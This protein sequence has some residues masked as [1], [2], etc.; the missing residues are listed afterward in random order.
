MKSN[1][2]R[3][4]LA[5]V[6]SFALWLYV[7]SVVSPES[8]DTFYDIPVSY[9]NDILEER[10]LMIVSETPTVTLKLK[11]NRSDLNE[12]NA[13]NITILVDLSE[14][15]T[16]GTQM[17][18]Y[19]VTYPANLPGNA[20]KTLSQTP[21][22][23]QLKVESKIKKNVPVYVEYI[24]SVP[25][26]FVAEKETPVMDTTIVEVS[27]PK[28]SV[29]LIH[30]ATIQ[31]DL[32]DKTESIVGA[33]NYVLCNEEGEPVDAQMVVTNVEEINMSVKI[34]AIKE[35]PLVLNLVDGGGATSDSCQ[36]ELSR[37]TIV[38]S[39]NDARLRE[40]EYIEL[41]TV[42]LAELMDETN[43]I[44]FQIVLPDGITNSSGVSEVTA[45]ITFPDLMRKKFT[46]SKEQFQ[47]IGV[48]EGANVVWITEVV[49]VELRGLRETIQKLSE[50][51]I[52]VTVDFT[53]EDLGSISKTPKIS[54]PRA[55]A[56]VGEVSVSSVTAT[57]QMG[58]PDATTSTS[59]EQ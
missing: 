3:L 2:V 44:D 7:I 31:V 11:G 24:G 52:I 26:G 21:N 35:I 17:L 9:Q 55:Y 27:G 23:L 42:N 28:S 19:N 6:I 15:K 1:F 22:L 33:F 46:I 30:Q 18:S 32:T 50:K 16:P 29:D 14:I 56:S 5:L 10:G 36:V 47:T 4:V 40:L 38:V 58:E 49:E 39:G 51:D 37:E 8:E 13:S 20:F 41:G 12:L 45:T 34:Q 25:E 53:G 59:P 54:L 57:L 48:P 43:T